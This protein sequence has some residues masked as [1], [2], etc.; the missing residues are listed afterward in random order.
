MFCIDNTLVGPTV[1]ENINTINAKFSRTNTIKSYSVSNLF[2][3]LNKSL[4][5]MQ[6]KF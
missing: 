1:S 6:G 3:F 5:P 2:S 4:T